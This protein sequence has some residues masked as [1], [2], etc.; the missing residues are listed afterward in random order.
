MWTKDFLTG[1][2]ISVRVDGALSKQFPINSGVP[3]GSVISPTLFLLY[4]N[5]LLSSTTNPIHSFADDSTLHQSIHFDSQRSSSCGIDVN[6]AMSANSLNS[7]LHTIMNWGSDNLV[8]FNQSKT[9]NL[10]ISC[11]K[12]SNL[13][14]VSMM[15][16]ILTQSSSINIL[17]MKISSNLSWKAHILSVAAMASKKLGFLFRAKKYFTSSQLL[18]LYKAQVRPSME[19]C[20]HIW[21]GPPALSSVFL[22]ASRTRPFDLLMMK[23]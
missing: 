22:I 2:S 14:S 23:H 5:D 17:G 3:Q 12:N 21:A 15:G 9:Q 13:P 18:T 20:G 19:Y 4:I 7:D 6:R 11:K 8:K 10:L 1:R 16:D